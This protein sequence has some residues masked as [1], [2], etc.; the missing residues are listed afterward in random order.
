MSS[1]YK[2][3]Q[4]TSL[5]GPEVGE[6]F[7]LVDSDF[8]TAAQGWTRGDKTGPLDLYD[9]KAPGTV[10]RTSD[11][12]RDQ[13]AIQAGIDAMIDFRGDALYY[14]PGSYSIGTTALELNSAGMRVLGPN[15]GHPKRSL[16]TVTDAIGAGYTVSVDDVEIANHTLIPITALDQISVS[17]GAD[18]GYL[19]HLYW[20]AAGIATSTATE[21]CVATTAV[22]WLAEKCIFY[23]DDEQGPAF[24]LTSCQRWTIQ[25]CDFYVGLTGVAW[26]SVITFATSALG[27]VLRRNMFRG[28]G[29]ATPAVFTNIITGIANVNGQLMAYHNFVDGS[30][31]ATASAFETTFGTTT[32]V[33][34]AENYQTGDASGEGGIVI[35]LA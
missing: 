20:N 1:L 22:D 27:M 7:Y 10:F 21:F 17:S 19:H 31:L 8:R 13:L 2:E 11:Y 16:V 35:A 15:V 5:G 30:A 32:D 29:G 28:C 18:R 24:T 33:E 23:V 9:Q 12:T 26:A 14:T 6:T 25:D 34:L 3:I 4:A